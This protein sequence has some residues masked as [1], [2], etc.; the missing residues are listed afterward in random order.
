MKL[1]FGV[2]ES[3]LSL[4]IVESQPSLSVS[5]TTQMDL[6]SLH[7]ISDYLQNML[8][9]FHMFLG[10]TGPNFAWLLP[11]LKLPQIFPYHYM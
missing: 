6:Y 7:H 10:F 4:G 1:N 8:P 3:Q 11:N 5:T 9:Q 2:T